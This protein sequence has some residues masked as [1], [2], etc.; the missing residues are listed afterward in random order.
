MY[1]ILEQKEVV[2]ENFKHKGGMLFFHALLKLLEITKVTLLYEE[3]YEFELRTAL[4]TDKLAIGF[5]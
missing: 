3:S 1:V 2:E 4:V 5:F